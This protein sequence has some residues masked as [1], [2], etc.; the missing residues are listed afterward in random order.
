MITKCMLKLIPKPEKSLH[1]LIPY[2]DLETG[3]RSVLAVL[4]A[5]ANP[6]AVEFM[7]RKVVKREKISRESGTP[8]P[9]QALIFSLPLTAVKRKS[10]PMLQESGNWF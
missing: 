2:P 6:T 4:R 7:D 1:A 9:R 8:A 3:I 10:Q 5:N